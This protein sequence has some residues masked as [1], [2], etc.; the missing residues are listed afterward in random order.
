LHY[1]NGAGGYRD[2]T[3]NPNSS[4]YFSFDSNI[5]IGNHTLKAIYAST[6]DTVISFVSVPPRS[7]VITNMRFPGS[8]WASAGGG[9]G[10]GSSSSIEYITGTAKA[11]GGGKQ[12]IQFRIKNNSDQMVTLTWMKVTYSEIAF[13]RRIRFAGTRVFNNTNPRAGSDETVGFTSPKTLIPYA[14]NL[15][16]KI[17]S[18]KNQATGGS[19]VNM[20]DVDFTVEFS[21]GSVITFKTK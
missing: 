3:L 12:N 16:I 15:V 11:T 4:G 17:E 7:D 14:N 10:G 6:N 21:D 20:K 19:N 18:F 1:P 8:L 9:G 13:Y 2:S 5:P